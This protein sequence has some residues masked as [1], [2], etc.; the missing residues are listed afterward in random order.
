MLWSFLIS[1]MATRLMLPNY[2]RSFKVWTRWKRRLSCFDDREPHQSKQRWTQ[3]SGK[4]LAACGAGSL[5]PLLM[6]NLNR[7]RVVRAVLSVHTGRDSYIILV[8]FIHRWY[9]FYSFYPC[10][11]D[12]C[13]FWP[14]KT[15]KI[16]SFVLFC[17]SK[18]SNVSVGLNIVHIYVWSFF[19]RCGSI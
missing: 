9:S 6:I 18:H 1:W 4:V 15:K 2:D 17:V 12:S 16:I 19:W 11:L 5:E 10:F 14:Q 3:S 13:S 7:D 8:K